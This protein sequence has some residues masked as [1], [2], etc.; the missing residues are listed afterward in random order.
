M[1]DFNPIKRRMNSN[2]KTLKL[3]Q[4]SVSVAAFYQWN[5]AI[6]IESEMEIE[7]EQLHF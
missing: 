6:I 7:F 1:N 3:S 2:L 5:L 4:I